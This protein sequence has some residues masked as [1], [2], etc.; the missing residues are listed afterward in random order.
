[1][2]ALFP[3]TISK[4][5]FQ[6]Q[7]KSVKSGPSKICHIFATKTG[8]ALIFV[9]NDRYKVAL[10]ISLNSKA[11]N[12]FPDREFGSKMVPNRKNWETGSFVKTFIFLFPMCFEYKNTLCVHISSKNIDF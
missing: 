11:S 2:S 6:N 3:I 8:R 9:V 10:A 5:F 12:I 7:S 1:M 4:R